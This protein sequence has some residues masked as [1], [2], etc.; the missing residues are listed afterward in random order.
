M[1]CAPKVEGKKNTGDTRNPVV[2]LCTPKRAKTRSSPL[3]WALVLHGLALGTGNN[4]ITSMLK[5][6]N[7]KAVESQP[8]LCL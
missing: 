8:K 4:V 6:A 1:T 2:I 7:K 5:Q 3:S